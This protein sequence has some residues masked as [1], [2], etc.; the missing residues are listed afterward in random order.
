MK[1]KQG[2]K[3]KLHIVLRDENGNIKQEQTI[4]NTITELLDAHVADQ[5]TDQGDA[6]IGFMSIGSGLIQ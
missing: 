4:D 2:I 6:A 1:D 5:L 3:G